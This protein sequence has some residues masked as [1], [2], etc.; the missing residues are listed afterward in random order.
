MAVQFE[1]RRFTTEQYYRMI[2]TGVIREG[3]RVELIDGEI[4]TMAAMGARHAA[5][6]RASSVAF[7]RALS[8]EIVVSVQ[9]PIHLAPGFEPEPDLVL[10]HG[11]S[12]RYRRRHP[13]PA[14]ILL[15]V[16]VSDSSLDYDRLVKLP[17]YAVNG[18]P[19]AWLF[20]L[21]AEQIFVHREPT[22][23]GYQVVQIARPGERVSPLAFPDISVAVEELLG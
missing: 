21:A 17:L 19:E 18:L 11:P 6:V 14:D 16:E 2:E 13:A 5:S 12:A 10:A 3:E 23:D 22:A 1:R 15:V 8:S 4:V 20:D 7:I 9:M